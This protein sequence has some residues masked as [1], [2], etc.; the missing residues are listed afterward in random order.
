MLI[1]TFFQ[2]L[3][4]LSTNILTLCKN[5]QRP[6]VIHDLWQKGKRKSRLFLSKLLFE[7]IMWYS[8]SSVTSSED[9][10]TSVAKAEGV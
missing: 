3:Y 9:I 7:D 4:P 5:V 6:L 1:L 10:A 8:V 2:L